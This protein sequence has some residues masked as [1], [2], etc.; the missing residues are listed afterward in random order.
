MSRRTAIFIGMLVVAVF[1]A[2]AFLWPPAARTL[3]LSV[4][5]PPGT[6]VIGS[7][8]VD[9]VTSAID[10]EA[11]VEF[12]MTGRSVTYSIQ[13]DDRPGEMTA[14]IAAEV[15]GYASAGATAR[16]WVHGGFTIRNGFAR[17]ETYWANSQ[18]GP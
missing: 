6:R 8:D 17:S 15:H 9:G 2:A 13:M 7:Y 1:A 18:V 5:A 12:V 16:G 4:A 3:T 14:R 10:A 11:P